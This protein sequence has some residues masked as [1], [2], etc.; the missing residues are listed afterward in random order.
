M[1]A[2]GLPVGPLVSWYGDDFTGAA[3]QM[4]AMSL[5][6]LPAVLFFDVPTAQQRAKFAGYRGIGFAGIARSKSPTWMAENLPRA[7]RSLAEVGAPISQYKVCSTLDSS[8]QVGSIGRAIEIAL[9]YFSAD[10]VPLFVAAP[11]M[12]RYQLFANLFATAGGVGYRLDRHPLSCHPVTPMLEADVRLHL[13]KQTDLKIGLVDYPNLRSGRGVEMLAAQ[14]SAGA[15]IVALDAI[16]DESLAAAG[17]LMWERR[18]ARTFAV[19]S[20]GIA[21]AL[22]AYF[23]RVGLLQASESAFRRGKVA[24]MAV[25][26][27]SCSQITSGQITWAENHGFQPIRIDPR[28]A[29]DVSAWNAEMGWVTERAISAVSDGKDPLIFSARGPED[30]AVREFLEA[31][32][33]SR[34]DQT[35]VNEAIGRG[36]GDVLNTLIRRTNIRRAVIA[37]GDTSGHGAASLGI[38]ALTLAAATVPG[39]ALFQAHSEDALL[40]RLEI[41]LKGGQMG[42]PDYF[43][44]IKDGGIS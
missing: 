41:A 12:G 39:A 17:E 13:A 14:I 6:G 11:P 3:A 4:E 21:Y 40:D 38:Y 23:R 30:P 24:R 29:L 27:G 19:G 26:S 32:A 5:A 43:G 22:I 44:Q 10:W 2:A 16:D 18:A 37:G 28:A 15:R 20:Q 35:A 33:I 42:T 31:L 9:P 7:L 1:T 34:A 36:L 8:P 25:V